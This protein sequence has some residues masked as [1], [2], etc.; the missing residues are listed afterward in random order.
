MPVL[1]MEDYYAI[2][3]VY[4]DEICMS[5]ILAGVHFRQFVLRYP[6]LLDFRSHVMNWG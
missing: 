2:F 6:G 4:L 5:T 1:Q 3:L